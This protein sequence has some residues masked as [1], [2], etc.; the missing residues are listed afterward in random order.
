[1]YGETYVETLHENLHESLM[2]NETTK[3][4]L[5]AEINLITII[6]ITMQIWICT[7]K[8]KGKNFSH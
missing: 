8:K 1:M 6:T 3:Y 5:I 4:C 2:N 7:H